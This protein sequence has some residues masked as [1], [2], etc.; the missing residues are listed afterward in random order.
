MQLHV[1][2]L[3]LRPILPAVTSLALLALWLTF[4]AVTPQHTPPANG[5]APRERAPAGRPPDFHA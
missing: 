5:K 2:K 3:E 4:P 1:C